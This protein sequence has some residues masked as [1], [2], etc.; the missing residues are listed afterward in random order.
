MAKTVRE[1]KVEA[2]VRALDL[3]LPRSSKRSKCIHCLLLQTSRQLAKGMSK[4][5]GLSS[6]GLDPPCHSQEQSLSPEAPSVKDRLSVRAPSADLSMLHT[7]LR[8]SI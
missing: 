8:R 1:H 6:M 2:S 4:L 5:K 3:L 7:F